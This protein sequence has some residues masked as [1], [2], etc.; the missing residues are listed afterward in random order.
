MELSWTTFSLDIV[1]FLILVWILKHFFYTPVRRVIERRRRNI[2]DS[3]AQA[4]QKR[5]E[6]KQLEEQYQLRL[7]DWDKEK[8][9]SREKLRDEIAAERE[10]MMAELKESVGREREKERVLEQRRTAEF[11]RHVEEQAVSHGTE[12]ASRLLSR[13]AGPELQDRLFRLLVGE[14]PNISDE[15]RETLQSIEPNGQPQFRVI[16][17]Y[18]IDAGQRRELERKLGEVTGKDISCEYQQDEAL[19]AGFRIHTGPMV[20]RANLQDELQL[21]SKAGNVGE[22]AAG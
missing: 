19:I 7:E 6:A 16:S 14:L 11:K 4:E 12:F 9:Q 10:R 22:N 8:K 17:A 21:F 15:Q 2:E 13:V 1:N 18:P 5:A 3:L 20:L